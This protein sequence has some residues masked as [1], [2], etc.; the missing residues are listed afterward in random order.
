MDYG[1]HISIIF[2]IPASLRGVIRRSNPML[3]IGLLRFAR[4]DRFGTGDLL[5]ELMGHHTS[6]AEKKAPGKYP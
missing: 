4:N 5:K 3:C 1:G 6:S 2:H